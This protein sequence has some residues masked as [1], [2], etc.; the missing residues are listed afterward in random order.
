M[1]QNNEKFIR[2]RQLLGDEAMKKLSASCVA[3]FGLGGV[4]GYAVEA[5]VRSG[6]GE[7]VL[8]DFDTI[9][10]SNI[11]RQILA[12]CDTVGKKKTA[13]A[14]I[15]AKSINPDVHIHVV[16][17][18]VSEQNLGDILSLCKIDYIVDAID[19]VTS[20]I[21]LIKASSEQ[22]IPVVS[23]MGTGNKLCPEMLCITDI[24]KTHT[25][26]LARVM[27][28]KLAECGIRSLDV[29][30]SPEQPIKPT[31]TET[32]NGR[33]PPASVSFV[34]SV[35][36]LMIGGFVVKKL[37]SLDFGVQS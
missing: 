5:L 3:V 36:G 6:V 22:G 29:L 30:F 35:A 28:K 34:P 8:V 15:R 1:N 37:A 25:C 12:T 4:G 13:V 20:K 24:K 23:S 18:F 16:D 21:A 26:P 32:E 2:T 14:E 31:H 17:E 9:S 33:H 7:L 19:T 27:R 10:E 11:N